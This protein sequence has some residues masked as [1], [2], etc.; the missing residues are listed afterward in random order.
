MLNAVIRFSLQ[1]RMLS[2]ALSVMLLVYGGA[3]TLSLPIDIFPNL[4]RPRV[5]VM[6]ESPGLAP[7]EVETLST[8]R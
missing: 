3:V 5:V 4:T 1:H 2:L 6:T 7:E 8:L